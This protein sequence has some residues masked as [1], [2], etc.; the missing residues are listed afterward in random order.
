MKEFGY[1][2]ITIEDSEGSTTTLLVSE[3]STIHDYMR[4]FKRALLW[5]TFT[6]KTIE[7]YI[8]EE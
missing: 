5:L 8:P 4:A 7:E 6:E 2:K 1:T 3:D